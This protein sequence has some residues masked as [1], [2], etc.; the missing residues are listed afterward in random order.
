[1]RCWPPPFALSDILPTIRPN[2]KEVTKNP[3]PADIELPP[4]ALEQRLM[5]KIMP[6]VLTS[7]E[8]GPEK[9]KCDGEKESCPSR[10]L[11]S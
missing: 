9:V 7:K 10:Q 5:L 4:Q 8:H 3:D 6:G 11:P 2:C 1:M